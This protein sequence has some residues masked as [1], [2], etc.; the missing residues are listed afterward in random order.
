LLLS[1]VLPSLKIADL[2][3]AGEK[4]ENWRLFAAPILPKGVGD[5]A[6]ET[7]LTATPT[8]GTDK[9]TL[10]WP[11][12]VAGFLAQSESIGLGPAIAPHSFFDMST[13]L[14]TA[15]GPANTEGW[16]F[17]EDWQSSLES[18]L[19]GALDIGAELVLLIEAMDPKADARPLADAA[20]ATLRD[21]AGIGIDPAPSGRPLLFS[22]V[23]N[24]DVT[25][26]AAVLTAVKNTPAFQNIADWKK[27]FGD[28][29]TGIFTAKDQPC[30]TEIFPK[31][32]S[33][34]AARSR[35]PTP[36]RS[37]INCAR[38]FSTP[39]IFGH[40][41][42]NKSACSSRISPPSRNERSKT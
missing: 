38:K 28:P 18:R 16:H 4:P 9:I 24:F 11:Y 21:I 41:S 26:Q 6:A 32:Q 19:S 34:A 39:P 23:D 33:G 14:V 37:S 8:L 3:P 20:I 35:Q 5:Q 12:T 30:S 29:T 27:F 7:L 15:P 2:L 10:T 13:R 1:F 40:F 22:L 31:W 17:D 25:F 42:A 36:P